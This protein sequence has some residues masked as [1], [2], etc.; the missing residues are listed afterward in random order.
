[1][2]RI[3]ELTLY[4]FV[5]AGQG[6]ALLDDRLSVRAL[7]MPIFIESALFRHHFGIA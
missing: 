6:H 5:D 1:M 4:G 2:G 7:E 3:G